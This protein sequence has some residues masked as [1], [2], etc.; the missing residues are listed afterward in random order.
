MVKKKLFKIVWDRN[1]LDNLKEILDFLSTQSSQAP[2]I[3]KDSILSRL[4]ILKNNPLIY[5]TDK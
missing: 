5:E 2:G 1:A 4:N 3:V